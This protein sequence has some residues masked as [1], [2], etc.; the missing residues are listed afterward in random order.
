MRRHPHAVARPQGGHRL[1][2]DPSAG[3]EVQLVALRQQSE[4]ERRF[5]QR[6]ALADALAW[7][8]TEWEVRVVPTPGRKENE[9]FLDTLDSGAMSEPLRGLVREAFADFTRAAIDVQRRFLNDP[10]VLLDPT[11]YLREGVDLLIFLCRLSEPGL[12]QTPS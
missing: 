2:F 11:R 5:H 7:P 1:R 9:R 8:A 6:E 3:H 10:M 12:G 4:H